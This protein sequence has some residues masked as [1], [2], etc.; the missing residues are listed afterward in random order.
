MRLRIS[1]SGPT[2]RGYNVWL[3]DVEQTRVTD[4]ALRMGVGQVNEAVI[5]Y[6]VTEV[7][8]DVEADCNIIP[9]DD[10]ETLQRYDGGDA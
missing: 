6:L 7:D 8:L 10:G 4:V 1:G 5:T 9:P 2:G 3:D